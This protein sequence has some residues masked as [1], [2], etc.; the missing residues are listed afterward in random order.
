[1][2]PVVGRCGQGALLDAVAQ[3]R[4]AGGAGDSAPGGHPQHAVLGE[5]QPPGGRVRLEPVI[6]AAQPAQVAQLPLRGHRG[7]RLTL[8]YDGSKWDDPLAVTAERRSSRTRTGDKP[9]RVDKIRLAHAACQHWTA[10]QLDYRDLRKQVRQVV[11][12]IKA[13]NGSPTD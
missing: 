4:R 5:H 13:A 12:F 7:A 1:L 10:D 9:P 8:T 3:A 6:P 11:N 2:A